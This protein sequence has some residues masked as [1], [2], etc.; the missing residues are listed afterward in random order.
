MPRSHRQ[1]PPCSKL[2][3]A[4]KYCSSPFSPN[5]TWSTIP[6]KDSLMP[7]K[8]GL[9]CD[10]G[11]AGL[12]VAT[13]G[14][15]TGASLQRPGST[16]EHMYKGNTKTGRLQQQADQQN[17]AGERRVHVFAACCYLG[18][19]HSI[20]RHWQFSFQSI[21]RVTAWYNSLASTNCLTFTH[22]WGWTPVAKVS[23]QGRPAD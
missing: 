8:Y 10:T 22:N 4:L 23:K 19:Y 2:S 3:A 11:F 15:T 5:F 21:H 16:V 6:G 18:V 14:H 20:I 9:S 1:N 13:R 17:R 7:D 12:S